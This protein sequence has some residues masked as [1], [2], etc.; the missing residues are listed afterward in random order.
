[1][2]RSTIPAL[3]LVMAAAACAS[4]DATETSV[5]GAD[6]S[7]AAATTT[8]PATTSAAGG[9]DTTASPTTQAP[10][11]TASDTGSTTT[12]STTTTTISAGPG[13]LAVTSVVFG[14]PTYVTVTNVGGSPI[15]LGNHWLCQ[16]PAYIQL[17]SFEMEPGDRVAVGLGE[18]PPADLV[19]LTAIFELGD[20]LGEVSRDDG[21][22]AL[23]SAPSFADPNSILDYVE[24]GSAGHGRSDVA[25]AAGIWTEGAFVEVPVEALSLSSSGIPSAGFD[26]WFA[27]IGG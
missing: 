18:V 2:R 12:M 3:V 7:A 10:T 13:I 6:T 1:M 24:W 19:G 4:D 14:P 8:V 20:A 27:D 11:T 9:S 15:E 16:R 21:E 17:P 23:Y 5:A 22:I 25:V 26:D